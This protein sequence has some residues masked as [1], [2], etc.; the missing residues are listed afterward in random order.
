MIKPENMKDE[1][2]TDVL[3]LI[4][5]LGD[6]PVLKAALEELTSDCAQSIANEV[7]EAGTPAQLDFL[8]ENDIDREEIIQFTK[9]YERRNTTTT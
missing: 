5:I 1:R 8:L 4:V 3:R 9:E 7:I 6:S 2:W